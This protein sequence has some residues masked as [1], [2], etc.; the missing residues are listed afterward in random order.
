MRGTT[1]DSFLDV[2]RSG[3]I[4]TREDS[5]IT[6]DGGVN[7]EPTVVRACKNTP[8][9]SVVAARLLEKGRVYYKNDQ[10]G[11]VTHTD[12]G[13][14]GSSTQRAVRQ[15]AP[16]ATHRTGG[17]NCSSG[18]GEANV[19]EDQRVGDGI[20][21]NRNDGMANGG[22]KLQLPA[23]SE[24][25][26][27]Q[28]EAGDTVTSKGDMGCWIYAGSTACNIGWPVGSDIAC[29]SSNT[30]SDSDTG[31]PPVVLPLS[32]P[33]KPV[34]SGARH[35]AS[36]RAGAVAPPKGT[37]PDRR[38]SGNKGI[39][40]DGKKSFG[41]RGSANAQR[42]ARPGVAEPKAAADFTD[43]LPS[44]ARS[45]ALFFSMQC[46]R[47]EEG[48]K[49]SVTRATNPHQGRLAVSERRSFPV[50]FVTPTN[51][52]ATGALPEARPSPAGND[53]VEQQNVPPT[54]LSPS[55]GKDPLGL[56]GKASPMS[57]SR[58]PIAASRWEEVKPE[59]TPEESSSEALT[60]GNLGYA[61]Q[62]P[63]C[64]RAGA[65][66]LGERNSDKGAFFPDESGESHDARRERRDTGHTPGRWGRAD[67][68]DNAASSDDIG[69]DLYERVTRSGAVA[70]PQM[71][72]FQVTGDHRR[73]TCSLLW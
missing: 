55:T 52:S 44:S 64:T 49:K 38:R 33:R 39:Q 1:K 47:P 40:S 31:E 48:M 54:S 70:R 2:F 28:S 58:D 35:R 60:I 12:A 19:V 53:L 34:T 66:H 27:T 4:G 42:P 14:T 16:Q 7:C 22:G 73:L 69:R 17:G 21:C 25:N 46:P 32:R 56:E 24:K 67:G 3:G 43:S 29:L 62:S 61:K 30:D 71:T 72:P 5:P 8:Y 63:S 11:V 37:D 26:N 36:R 23:S 68:D 59:D 45:P 6:R 57:A 50:R 51:V 18:S 65:R 41:N 20:N 13:D 9:F 10:L 15:R